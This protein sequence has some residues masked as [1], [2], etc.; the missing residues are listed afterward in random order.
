MLLQIVNTEGWKALFSSLS[1]SIVLCSNPAIQFTCYEWLKRR[2][3]GDSA[4][5]TLVRTVRCWVLS[6]RR[7]PP[8]LSA[9]L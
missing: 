3:L 7:T 8:S 5:V 6:L 2:T 9:S 1:A 4:K